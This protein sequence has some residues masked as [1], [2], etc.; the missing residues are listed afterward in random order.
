MF[1]FKKISVKTNYIISRSLVAERD[2][3]HVLVLPR[4]RRDVPHFVRGEG[5]AVAGAQTAGGRLPLGRHQTPHEDVQLQARCTGRA[6]HRHCTQGGTQGSRVLPF[7][8]ADPQ[9]ITILPIN[10]L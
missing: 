3:S 4:Q 8:W 10:V 5:G 9:V 6:D 2:T 1:N 7:Q